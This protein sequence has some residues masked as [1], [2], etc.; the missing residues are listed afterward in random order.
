MFTKLVLFSAAWLVGIY[1][2]NSLLARRFKKINV[3]RALVYITTV[4]MLGLYGE[5]FV[6]SF[7][8]HFFNTP[9]W[10]YDILP[11]HHAYT[12]SFAAVLWGAYGFHLYL[13]HDSLKKWSADKEIRLMILFAFEALIIESLVELTSKVLRGQYIYYYY[14]GGLWHISAFQNFPFYFI[15]G[16]LIVK[17]VKRFQADPRFFVFLNSWLIVMVLFFL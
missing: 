11:I 5:I 7:Y 3:K 6:D 4:A 8:A 14:P 13:L 1:L 17:T 10:R 2:F 16:L 12:S 15:C 9:L